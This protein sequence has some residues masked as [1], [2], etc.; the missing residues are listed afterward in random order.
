MPPLDD[1]PGTEAHPS[2]TTGAVAELLEVLLARGQDATTPAISPSQL[3]A[4]LVVEQ[5]EGINLRTLG[6]MLGSRPPSVTR[7]CDRMEAM[8]LL[9]RS[10]SRTSGREVELYPTRQGRALLDEYRAIR[11]RELSAVLDLMEPA[12][13]EALVVG[14]T[15]LRQAA[16]D[17]FAAGARA[18][19]P[20][21]TVAPHGA[22]ARESTARGAGVGPLR[23]TRLS[24][25]A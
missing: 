15:G 22:A 2:V 13:I 23:T 18:A 24:D 5:S 8:G 1:H 25:T 11:L 12:A 16:A 19:G 21:A 6:A 17:L 20:E 10:R 14:L 4:L 7:L 9:T 3:R